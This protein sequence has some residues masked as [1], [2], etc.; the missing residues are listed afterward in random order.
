MLPDIIQVGT[1]FPMARDYLKRPL[2]RAQSG[3][4]DVHE[5]V[6]GNLCR[7]LR[8]VGDGQGA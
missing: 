2:G 5:I 6:Q 3:A 7:I 1:E 8:P 4:S